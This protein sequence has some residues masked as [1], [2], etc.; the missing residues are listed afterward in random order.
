MNRA[1]QDR[2][3]DAQFNINSLDSPLYEEFLLKTTKKMQDFFIEEQIAKSL[4]DIKKMPTISIKGVDENGAERLIAADLRK[5]VG[6]DVLD[7]STGFNTFFP[8]IKQ[9]VIHYHANGI[10]YYTHYE[11]TEENDDTFS[12][13]IREYQLNQSR[14]F[15]H[16]QL[17][18][19]DLN[20]RIPFAFLSLFEIK[21]TARILGGKECYLKTRNYFSIEELLILSRAYEK[22][23]D[24]AK[25]EA[26]LILNNTLATIKTLNYLDELRVNPKRIDNSIFQNVSIEDNEF[27]SLK[28]IVI[29]NA[30]DGFIFNQELVHMGIHILKKNTI[31]QVL[32]EIIENDVIVKM[33]CAVGYAVNTGLVLMKKMYESIISI[34]GGTCELVIGALQNY[35]KAKSY[36]GIN[37][38]TANYLKMLMDDYQVKLLSYDQSFYHGKF[39]YL[40]GEKIAYIIVGSSNISGNAFRNNYEMDI[41]YVLPKEDSLHQKFIEWYVKLTKDCKQIECFDIEKFDD[42]IWDN[43]FDEI[44]LR[45]EKSIEQNIPLKEALDIIDHLTDEETQFRL[46]AW[47]AYGPTIKKDNFDSIPALKGYTMFVFEEYKMV[48]FESFEPRNRYYVFGMPKGLDELKSQLATMK[49]NEMA[50]SEFFID[51]GNH[52]KNN[53]RVLEKIARF[54]E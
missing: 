31:R 34:N 7:S 4:R 28:N 33:N 44:A 3:I 15:L 49:K 39:Y 42:F 54:F 13:I 47:L 25:N 38:D 17:V 14:F 12:M 11:V 43:G 41:L 2:I 40:E 21:D 18:I 35:P 51:R 52:I 8:L 5:K 30:K 20:K 45:K 6:S 48:V 29:E 10:T 23:S 46:K 19:K 36:R 24:D 32:E 1:Q 22:S 37:R 53:E 16:M 26:W 9:A 50:Y 27:F